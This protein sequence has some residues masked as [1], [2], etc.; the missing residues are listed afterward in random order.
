MDEGRGTRLTSVPTAEPQRN[1]IRTT[2]KTLLLH[3]SSAGCALESETLDQEVLLIP[4]P[5]AYANSFL[6][7]YS[8]WTKY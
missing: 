7:K 3:F 2:L 8:P 1:G 6:V 4:M 5:T